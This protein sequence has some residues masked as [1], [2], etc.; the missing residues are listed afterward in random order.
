MFPDRNDI[1]TSQYIAIRCANMDSPL[2]LMYR[3]GCKE[4]RKHSGQVGWDINGA[5]LK[6][7]VPWRVS[8]PD[9]VFSILDQHLR[10]WDL[11]AEFEDVKDPKTR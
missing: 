2:T 3:R 11:Y 7:E 10:S 6:S 9:K 5:Y 1:E 4:P 8:L